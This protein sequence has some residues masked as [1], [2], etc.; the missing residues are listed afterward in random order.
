MTVATILLLAF[1]AVSGLILSSLFSGMET[2]I[3]TLNRVRLSLRRADG[4]RRAM[5]LG[6]LLDNRASMLA[7]ILLGNNLAHAMGSTAVAGLLE[8]S[9][10]TEGWVVVVNIAILVPVLLLFGEVL[11]KDLFR[12]HGDRWCYALSA[13]LALTGRVL[14]VCGVLGL[15]QGVAGAATRLTRGGGDVAAVSARQRMSDLLREGTD[16]G[17]LTAEQQGLVDRALALRTRKVAD[18]MVPWSSVHALAQ[19]DTPAQREAA[20]DTVWTR[21]PIVDA[22]GCVCGA[23]SVLD[24]GLAPDVPLGD[25]EQ[26]VERLL[27]TTTVPEALFQLRTGGRALGIVE[28]DGKPIG[29]VTA[30]DLVEALVGE[31]S[32]W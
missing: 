10:L 22:D 27:A 1:F 32:A 9:G 30:K 23:V 13:P 12:L 26:D 2:G 5:R 28:R 21:F 14:Q 29:L 20:L 18:E 3:Y 8:G 16:A 4:H 15:V 6:R 25:L 24:L 7:V 17:I 11:P 19:V 31:L